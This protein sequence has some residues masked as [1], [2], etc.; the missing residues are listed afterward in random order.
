MT[1]LSKIGLV[2]GALAFIGG[3]VYTRHVS[4]RAEAA[5]VRIQILTSEIAGYTA[6]LDKAAHSMTLV[7]KQNDS[8]R[9]VATGH[10]AAAVQ[11]VAKT[12]PLSQPKADAPIPEWTAAYNAAVFDLTQTQLALAHA[13]DADS[14]DTQRADSAE[15]ELQIVGPQLMDLS[16][17]L[18]TATND[19]DAA[20]KALH[21]AQ[22]CSTIPLIGLRTPEIGV[23]VVM[24]LDLRPQPAI[25]LFIPLSKC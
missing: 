3:G 20:H 5:D 7:L 6:T 22:K 24:G 16:A 21:A 8:L 4:A 9:K 12:V 19:L 17:K 15:A 13:L 2:L 18:K 11:A 10:R 23:G 14:A 1:V 25:G